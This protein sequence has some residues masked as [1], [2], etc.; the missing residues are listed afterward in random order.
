M[1]NKIPSLIALICILIYVAAV[2][3][4]AYGVYT[5]IRSRR[6]LAIQ[7]LDGI[8]NLISRN[9]AIFFTE[10]FREQFRRQLADCTS[11]Y[12]III[13]GSQG[14]LGFEKETG[15]IIRWD[16]TPRFTSR[17][18]YITL[19]SRPLEIPGFRNVNLYSIF[20]SLD[21]EVLV[22]VLRQSLFAILGALLLSFLTMMIT[23]LRSRT[24]AYSE[25]SIFTSKIEEEESNDYNDFSLPAYDYPLGAKDNK[26]M[27]DVYDLPDFDS[28]SAP[29]ETELN[30]DNFHLDDF[31]DESDLKLPKNNGMPEDT[32]KGSPNGLY[33]PRSNI[34]WEAYTQDRLASELHICASS[35]QDL[36][37]LLMECGE[38]VDCD[39]ILYRKIAN[40]AVEVFNLRDLTF[41]YGNRGI[42]VII[43][44]TGLE[45]GISK[46]EAF[47]ARLFKSIFDSF[48]SK[49]DFLIGVS[50]RS[51][52]LIEAE[53][54]LLEASRSLE[55]A[56]T[57]PDSP[58]IAFKSDP[59]KYREYI[60]KGS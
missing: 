57:E 5:S 42:S 53:R 50:S 16:P 6:L 26:S 30:E 23:V 28:F 15:A 40:E 12:G 47:H 24:A 27:N 2:L 60:K 9:N 33:S 11:L 43:P 55:K 31:L 20:N 3:F 13:T 41:E 38:N 19:Q 46:A 14:N 25:H 1:R 45:Q 52:R 37:V 54:L 48:H 56:K 22:Y 49:N 18:G 39:D 58:I 35:E 59:E 10:P 36:V 17:F 29:E 7:E 4:G 21:Y 51:G 34:G 32:G 44:N 8:Q